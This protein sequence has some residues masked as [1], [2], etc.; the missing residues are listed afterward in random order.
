MATRKPGGRPPIP[1][2]VRLQATPA[3]VQRKPAEPPQVAAARKLAAEGRFA[4]AATTL[5]NL[6]DALLAKDASRSGPPARWLL[7]AA[8]W[9]QRRD[10]ERARGLFERTLA[11]DDS[12]TQGWA[13]FA[14]LHERH[15]RPA[16]GCKAAVQVLKRNGTPNERMDAANLLVRQGQAHIGLPAVRKAYED[17]GRPLDRAGIVLTSALTAADWDF[18]EALTAQLRAAYAEG[19][20]DEVAEGPR[21]HLMWCAD[22][23]TNIEVVKHWSRRQIKAV[24]APPLP[25]IEPLEGRRLRV[26]YLSSDYRNHATSW[27]IHGLF[28]NHDRSRLELHAYCCG[29]D[30][31]SEL[32]RKVLSYFDGVHDVAGIDDTAAAALMRSHRLDVL[33]DLNGPTRFNRVS[34]LAHRPA[35]VQIGYLGYPGTSGGR[36]VDYIVGDLH[37][38]PPGAEKRF[39]EKVIRIHP[40][41]QVNDYAARTLPSAPARKEVGLPEGVRVAGMFNAI[42]KVSREVWS[43]WM[44]ILHRAPKAVLWA[45]DPGPVARGHLV[46]ASRAAGV[47]EGQLIWAPRRQQ[48]DHLARLQC[49]DLMLDPWPYGGHTTTGDA[50]FANVPVLAPEGT[51]FASRVSGALLKAAG[52]KALVA[53]TLEAYESLAVR[54]L[55]HP[56]EL[57]RLRE[58]MTVNTRRSDVF[59]AALQAR[60]LEAA[61]RVAVDR[62]MRGQPPRHITVK[63]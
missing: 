34:I 18:S 1:A 13:A 33:V 53:P 51:N 15:G 17:L 48:Q 11:L 16:D 55:N 39:P 19:R 6:A 21:T 3:P 7:Q 5:E 49:C 63:R 14:L 12:L 46:A 28:R 61:Y 22:E 35:P 58:F 40:T 42:D 31:G 41:Y 59:N 24:D 10:A 30:D 45:L 43:T 56:T 25:P 50:L 47:R 29:W 52:L 62:A 37:T 57:D 44:R 8:L 36:F 20:Y 54:L 26:G 4:E 32:R 38:V 2:G 27:L 23:A 60:Q 9:L